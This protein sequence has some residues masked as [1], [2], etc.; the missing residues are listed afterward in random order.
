M[1]QK[2]IAI[3]L[4]CAATLLVGCYPS[5]VRKE[6][7]ECKEIDMKMLTSACLI[8]VADS[9]DNEK[10]ARKICEKEVFASLAPGSSPTD[11]AIA[12][13]VEK[14]LQEVTVSNCLDMVE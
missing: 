12:Y 1:K 11:H 14:S 9:V 13:Q 8:S 6:I 7:N 5:E 2:I 10:I 3:V 4:I